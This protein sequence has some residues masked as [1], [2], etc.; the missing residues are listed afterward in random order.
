MFNFL[1]SRRFWSFSSVLQFAQGLIITLALVI[2]FTTVLTGCDDDG[3]QKIIHY[4]VYRENSDKSQTLWVVPTEPETKGALVCW[5]K[6]D[7]MQFCISGKITIEQFVAGE[8][9]VKKRDS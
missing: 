1:K 7:G 6:D 9:D 8:K 5:R 3:P 2:G 4:R